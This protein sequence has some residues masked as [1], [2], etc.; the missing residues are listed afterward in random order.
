MPY[1]IELKACF[2][3]WISY[4]KYHGMMMNFRSVNN[5]VILRIL[6]RIMG[7]HFLCMVSN[8]D[9]NMYKQLSLL[10]KMPDIGYL[11]Y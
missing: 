7:M 6:F 2:D 9:Y 4:N 3:Y 1:L 11:N 5:Y 8:Y 10:V